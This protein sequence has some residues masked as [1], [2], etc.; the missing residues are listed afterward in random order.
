MN[1]SRTNAN[2]QLDLSAVNNCF[3]VT[4]NAILAR[5]RST[6]PQSQTQLARWFRGTPLQWLSAVLG[7]LVVGGYLTCL[8]NGLSRKAGSVYD[9]SEQEKGN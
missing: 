5:L 2:R 3:E 6:G 7:Y 1:P 9:I 4:K 8:R